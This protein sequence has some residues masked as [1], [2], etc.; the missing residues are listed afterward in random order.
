M[1]ARRVSST[2]QG[3]WLRESLFETVIDPLI[4]APVPPKFIF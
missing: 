4:H 2:G 1:E 3:E